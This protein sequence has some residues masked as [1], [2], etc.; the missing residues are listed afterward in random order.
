MLRMETEAERIVAIL[1][2]VIEDSNLT[3]QDILGAGYRTEISEAIDYLTRRDGE[4]YDHFIE[5]I[6]G[7]VLARKIKIA[8]IEDNLNL[9]RIKDPKENDF[10]RIE[11]YRHALAELRKTE[12]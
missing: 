10:R 4:E 12:G 2:D 8:D 7:N 5:K 11:K 6:K 3:I 9:G 1:H